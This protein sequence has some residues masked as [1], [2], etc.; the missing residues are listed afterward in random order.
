MLNEIA[1]FNKRSLKK[2]QTII[3]HQ[4]GSSEICK[5]HENI[6]TKVLTPDS[7]GFVLQGKPDLTCD[8]I[9]PV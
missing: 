8:E 4:D 9:I 3:R 7:Y 5:I 2:T 1:N 6:S